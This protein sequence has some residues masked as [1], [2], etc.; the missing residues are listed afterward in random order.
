MEYVALSKV[1]ILEAK[2]H[3]QFKSGRKISELG[4]TTKETYVL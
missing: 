4:S 2:C 1:G 3:V